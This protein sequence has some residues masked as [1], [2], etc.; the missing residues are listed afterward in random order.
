MRFGDIFR[1]LQKNRY[2][3]FSFRDI[4]TFFPEEKE[5]NLKKSIFRWKKKKWIYPLKRG[6][7]ELTYPADNNIPDLHV[8]NRLYAPSYISLETALSYYSIIPEVSMAV[9]SVTTKPTRSFR[10]K[11]GLFIYRTVKRENFIGYYLEKNG[12]FDIFI[13]EPE[14]A[15]VDY[16]YFRRYR[17]GKHKISDER[18]DRGVV[19]KLNKRK[20]NKYG[21]LFNL[22]LGELYAFL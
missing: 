3:V 15:L 14:K 6:L 16:L 13:A 12:L 17:G 20:L 2:F 5:A 1:V 18:F 4:L 8:A 22:D 21:K 19:S 7:F 11:H 9:T 10:N